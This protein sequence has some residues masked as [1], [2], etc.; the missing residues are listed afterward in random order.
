MSTPHL[1]T[2][3][4]CLETSTW[5][6]LL[7]IMNSHGLPCSTRWRKD[8]LIQTLHPHLSAPAVLRQVVLN[9]GDPARKALSALL[10]AGG[11]LP[12]NPFA[13]AFGDVRPYRPWRED[14]VDPEPWQNP[15]SPTER[16]WYLGLLHL[17]PRRPKPGETQHAV[18]PAELLDDLSHLLL[19]PQTEQPVRLRTKPGTSPGLLWDIALL[20]ATLEENPIRPLHGRW[21]PPSILATLASRMGLD[22][23]A[24]FQPS[25][26]ERK[27]PYLAFVHYLAQ[28]AG[29]LSGATRLGLT[30]SGWEWLATDPATRWQILWQGWQDTPADLAKPFRFPWAAL[31]PQARKLILTEVSRLPLDDFVPLR[32]VVEQARLHDERQLLGQP[33]GEEEDIAASLI[34]GPLLWL[35]IVDVGEKLQSPRSDIADQPARSPDDDG[36]IPPATIPDLLLRLTSLGAWLLELP[37]CGPPSFP[38]IEPCTIRPPN[39]D[40][41]LVPP[42]AQ[43]IHLARLAPFSQWRSPEPPA[44]EQHLQLTEERIG[45]AIARGTELSQIFHSLQEALGRPASRRQRQRLRRWAEAGRQVRVRHLTVL[46]TGDPTLMGELRSQKLIRRHLG[47]ALSPTRSTLNPAELS[48]LLQTL[49]T[50]DLYAAL[51]PDRDSDSQEAAEQFSLSQ[52][53]ASLL[54]MAG[55]VYKGLGEHTPLPV[56]LSTEIMDTLAQQLTPAQREAAEH[57]AQQVLD[58][59]QATLRGYLGLPLWQQDPTHPKNVLP[60][61]ESALDNQQ[62]LRL[63]YW[64]AGREQALERR[65]TPYWI[66]RRGGTPYL[67]AYCHLRDAERTFRVDRIVDCEI[68]DQSFSFVE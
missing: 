9:L 26:S 18:L 37:D 24:D 6:R 36:E 28:A 30:S 23:A 2:L 67:I 48:S 50:L 11:Q 45:Q 65:V 32:Q 60:A 14:S 15:A 41:I 66:E 34:T 55:L 68:V 29:L 46:E 62:D 49:R 8:E 27:L 35:G 16:L 54:W 5:R 63:T 61:I 43:P 42:A 52:A 31:T 7:A 1:P 64:G 47:D 59:V 38:P 51:P 4:E 25:R 39:Y 56:P 12:A 20:L 53:D 33:W 3:Q 19:S 21:F 22:Q 44:L 13:T 17:L 57:I 58:Q 10:Q 40:L